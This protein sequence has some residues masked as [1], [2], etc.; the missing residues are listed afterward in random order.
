MQ[1]TEWLAHIMGSPRSTNP[2]ASVPHEAHT[3]RPRRAG[4][5]NALNS[6]LAWDRYTVPPE[7]DEL[8]AQLDAATGARST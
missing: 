7:F 6:I 4:T 3:P 2:S 1:A 8:I 5:G